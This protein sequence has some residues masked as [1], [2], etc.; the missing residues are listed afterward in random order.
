MKKAARAKSPTIRKAARGSTL[1]VGQ[2]F[3]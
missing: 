3:A 1:N 2:I